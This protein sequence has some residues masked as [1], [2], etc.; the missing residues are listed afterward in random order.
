VTTE[1]AA[2][3]KPTV[4]DAAHQ[5]AHFTGLTS[6]V[7]A[8]PRTARV[9]LAEIT[10]T[11]G[12]VFFGAGAATVDSYTDGDVTRV[13]IGISFGLAVFIM[14]MAFGRISGAHINPVVTLALWLAGKFPTRLVIPYMIAQVVGGLIAAS[15]LHGLFHASPGY[16]GATLPSG[17]IWISF[18]FEIV[19]TFVLIYVIFAVAHQW[20]ASLPLIAVAAASV[21]GLEAT[22]AGEISGASM[23]PARSF[24]PAAI[25][26][27]WD[28]H[29][30]YWTAPVI[31][32]ILATLLHLIIHNPDDR[33]GE[34]AA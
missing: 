23:N 24:G 9:L 34:T 16:L 14:V 2:E 11:F 32:A 30:I 18:G 19:L 5:Q 21:V 28:D 22:M 25:A 7:R 4:E 12:L 6:R 29:W 26:W 27:I 3:N 8:L 15:V 10:G 1:N 31:G 13:G 33:G 17:D 20:H